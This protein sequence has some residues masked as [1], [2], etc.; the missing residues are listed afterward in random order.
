MQIVQN[1]KRVPLNS[2]ES[3]APLEILGIDFVG[4]LPITEEGK[5]FIMNFQDHFTQ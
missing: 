5:R 4:P 1:K 3:N 2:I